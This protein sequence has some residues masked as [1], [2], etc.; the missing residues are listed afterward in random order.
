MNVQHITKGKLFSMFHRLWNWCSVKTLLCIFK[1]LRSCVLCGLPWNR[2][3]FSLWLHK[4]EMVSP[5]STQ[6]S[7]TLPKP[8]NKRGPKRGPVT[9][10]N[11]T[12]LLHGIST[13]WSAESNTSADNT[14]CRHRANPPR[15]GLTYKPFGWTVWITGQLLVQTAVEGH[16]T[17]MWEAALKEHWSEMQTLHHYLTRLKSRT[18][19][20]RL[21]FFHLIYVIFPNE[22]RVFREN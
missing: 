14:M 22:R 7:N 19:R 16:L 15:C 20:P 18:N 9:Q 1:E 10:H 5:N 2:L 3:F 12:F 6:S 17:S 8:T 13:Q 4:I 11:N 21:D